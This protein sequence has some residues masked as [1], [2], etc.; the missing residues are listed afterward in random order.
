MDNIVRCHTCKYWIKIENE[1]DGQC[2]RFPG[3]IIT[4]HLFWCGLHETNKNKEK[5]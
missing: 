2:K 3:K 1:N 4:N 5:R